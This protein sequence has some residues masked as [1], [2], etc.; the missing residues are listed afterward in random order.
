MEL[1]TAL[2]SN[3]DMIDAMKDIDSLLHKEG[4]QV[5]FADVVGACIAKHW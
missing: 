2:D 1:L 5:P 3:Q 4:H